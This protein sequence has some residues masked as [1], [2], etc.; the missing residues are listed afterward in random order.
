MASSETIAVPAVGC[1]RARALQCMQQKAISLLLFLPVRFICVTSPANARKGD[2][3][4][5]VLGR[6]YTRGSP[7]SA[8]LLSSCH[9]FFFFSLLPVG[10]DYGRLHRGWEAVGSAFA[11]MMLDHSLSLFFSFFFF[12]LS[13][14]LH[15]TVLL[16]CSHSRSGRGT[17]RYG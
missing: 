15:A 11:A 7:L 16:Y 3:P 8:F 10:F 17:G 13:S 14:F 2:S 1:L 4:V 9:P 12:S 5:S 6:R